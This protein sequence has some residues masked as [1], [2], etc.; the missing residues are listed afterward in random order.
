MIITLN[1][2]NTYGLYE[3]LPAPLKTLEDRKFFVFYYEVDEENVKLKV[4]DYKISKEPNVSLYR[5]VEEVAKANNLVISPRVGIF[6]NKFETR[7]G[8]FYQ[9]LRTFNDPEKVRDLYDYAI[10]QDRVSD[11]NVS[12]DAVNDINNAEDF[13]RTIGYFCPN[14]LQP[15]T[16]VFDMVNEAFKQKF[17]LP[18]YSVKL[19]K[20]VTLIKYD[21][22]VLPEM[23]GT[24]RFMVIGENA[25]ITPEQK[26]KLL[27]AKALVRSQE[28]MEKIYMYTGWA[29]SLKDGKWRT[30][31]ADD[32]AEI[33]TD[34]LIDHGGRKLYV[35]VTSSVEQMMTLLANPNRLYTINYG[36][37]L[38]DVLKHPTLFDYYPAL[39]TMP[40][41]YYYG[42]QTLFDQG[43]NPIEEFYYAYNER[44][45][46]VVINGSTLSGSSLS[47][48]LHETQHAVQRI[49]NFATGGNQLFARFVASVGSDKVRQIFASINKMSTMIKDRLFTEEDMNSLIRAV[50]G[51]IATSPRAKMYKQALLDSASSYQDYISNY[52]SVTF[53]LTLFIAENGDYMDSD[54]VQILNDKVG[55]IIFDLL[56]NVSVGYESANKVVDMFKRQQG[57]RDQDIQRILFQSYE[58]LYGEV[59]SR[60]VQA[61]RLVESQYKNYFFLTEWEQGPIKQLVVIDGVDTIIDTEKIEAAVETKDDVY[62]IH[63]QRGYSCV[64]ALHE[65]GHIV[66]DALDK[67]GHRNTIAQELK[68]SIEYSDIEEFFVDKFLLYLRN[69]IEDDGLKTD[70]SMHKIISENT[71][72]KGLL[73]EFFTHQES[74]ASGFEQI[75]AKERLQYLQTLLSMV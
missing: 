31:I 29:L 63:L 30:N 74:E 68:K 61:S 37:K 71:V 14:R 43:G 28:D 58:N 46:Y 19:K 15:L 4:Y 44:G 54:V 40:I 66:F 52:K 1:E 49:E 56:E 62:V 73:D 7:D 25:D 48:L 35:P 67:L 41:F 39:G 69:T 42:N 51:E 22:G 20:I 72:I 32:L 9:F 64:P 75:E 60:S 5:D 12:T 2:L 26:E 70:I 55:R 17:S 57:Y 47:I 34:H 24:F 16:Q 38:R 33:K 59:E 65:L 18:L 8:L 45:G 53:Y 6:K 27:E 3:S 36:G 13:K 10:T 11:L 50:K 21:G 23:G